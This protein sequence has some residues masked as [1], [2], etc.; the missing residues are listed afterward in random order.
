MSDFDYG[1]EIAKASGFENP[2]EGPR[3]ARLFGLLRIGTFAGEYQGKPK[4]PAPHAIAIFHLLG[5]ADKTEAGEPMFFTHDFS[6]KSGDKSFLHKSFIPAMGGMSKHKGFSTMVNELFALELT[7]GKEVGEDG[8]P[9]YINFKSMGVIP[10]DTLELMASAPAFAALEKP[11]GFL[12][13]SEL[14]EE[15]LA[16][17]HP[18]LEFAKIVMQTEEFKAGTHPCQALIQK[19]YDSD[20][21][22]YTAKTK[23]G[24]Q[25]GTDGSTPE[26]S[27]TNGPSTTGAA[28]PSEALV[29][30]Q[31]F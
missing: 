28:A 30:D 7:G 23:E 21:E 13:E 2:K 9:K 29:P 5:K 17:L 4:P 6:L 3:N 19:I 24:K 26:T 18:T 20:K 31:E 25:T 10:E 27:G 8:K 11:V 16:Y 14:T 15:A 22:R 1:G 12:K